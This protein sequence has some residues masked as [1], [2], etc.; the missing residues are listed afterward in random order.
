[1]NN[2]VTTDN[3]ISSQNQVRINKKYILGKQLGSGAF[4]EVYLCLNATTNEKVACKL[5]KKHCKFPQL[6][7]EARIMKL[8]GLSTKG[9][10]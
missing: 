4:G 9:K 10:F 5:E 7:R 6:L 8:L 2:G 1:M 3:G